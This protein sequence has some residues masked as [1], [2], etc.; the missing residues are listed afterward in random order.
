MFGLISRRVSEIKQCLKY[1]YHQSTGKNLPI[2]LVPNPKL[3]EYETSKK[4]M[5]RGYDNKPDDKYIDSS[6]NQY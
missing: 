4:D 5:R 6:E 1:M 3:R 2:Y